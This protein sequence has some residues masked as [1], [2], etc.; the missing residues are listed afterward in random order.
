MNLV[1]KEK[2]LEISQG[3]PSSSTSI[4][5]Q[6]NKNPLLSTKALKTTKTT[7]MVLNSKPSSRIFGKELQNH[8][9][10]R[11]MKGAKT[12]STQTSVCNSVSKSQKSVDNRENPQ[13]VMAYRDRIDKFLAQ[14]D[15][16]QK[17]ESKFLS[18]QMDVNGKMRGI[19][20]DWLVDVSAKFKL[21]PETFFSAVHL[22]DRFLERRQVLRTRLQLVGITCLMIMSKFEEIY[23]PSVRDYV[24]VC[25]RAYSQEELLDTEAEILQALQ[26]DLAV[27]SSLVFYR[28]M[29]PSLELSPKPS[30]FGEYLLETALLS[31]N[32]FRFSNRELACGAIFLVNKIFKCKKTFSKDLAKLMINVSE[33]RVKSCAKEL[34][35][36][37]TAV[38]QMGLTAIKRKFST[39]EKFEV[40]KYKIERASKGKSKNL[41]KRK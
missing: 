31:E 40:S 12:P 38:T 35:K 8:S 18:K 41:K 10:S 17:V 32:S 33:S 11:A 27:T 6:L 5:H 39:V 37:L 14:R 21:L 7:K 23:P 24:C 20:V 34:Y 19:L 30:V 28:G 15:R 3:H 25:D 1:M 36:I 22:L 4:R 9:T 26:F 16:E 13:L 2:N 29:L